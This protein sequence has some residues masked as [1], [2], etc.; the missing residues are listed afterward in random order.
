MRKLTAW[1]QSLSEARQVAKM[2]LGRASS[3]AMAKHENGIYRGVIIGHTRDYIVQQ[4]G[5]Q[6]AAVIHSKEAFG[7][8]Q[9]QF[10]WPEVG[11]SVSIQYAQARAIVR[12]IREH[13]YEQELSR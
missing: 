11:Q 8:R 10:P 6:A 13:T 4:I 2:I 5:K 1:Q 7:G 12:E 9:G 3:V